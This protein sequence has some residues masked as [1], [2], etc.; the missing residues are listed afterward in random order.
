MGR[1][2]NAVTGTVV[3]Q[4][5]Y[6]SFEMNV[7]LLKMHAQISL[8]SDGSSGALSIIPTAALRLS[9]YSWISLLALLLGGEGSC[10]GLK[11]G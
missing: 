8:I 10:S 3:Y 9:R 2:R 7:V 5:S 1:D 4:L 6:I 11:Y